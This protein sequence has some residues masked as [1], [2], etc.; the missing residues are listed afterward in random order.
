MAPRGGSTFAEEKSVL[1]SCAL[2]SCGILRCIDSEACKDCER[3]S[4]A[5]TTKLCSSAS[6]SSSCS[7]ASTSPPKSSKV[8]E[9]SLRATPPERHRA[10]RSRSILLAVSADGLLKLSLE[11]LKLFELLK[12]AESGSVSFCGLGRGRMTIRAGKISCLCS[13]SSAHTSGWLGLSPP[14]PPTLGRRRECVA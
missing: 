7:I 3:R 1:R 4:T 13:H 14:T 11:L 8:S 2:L 12:L 6:S 10:K 5:C 9:P